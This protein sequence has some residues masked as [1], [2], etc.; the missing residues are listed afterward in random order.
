MVSC[1][2]HAIL[3]DDAKQLEKVVLFI[4]ANVINALPIPWPRCQELLADIP[5]KLP[6][7]CDVV[8]ALSHAWSHQTHPDPT[9]VKA[10]HVKTLLRSA[11][12][13]H[14]VTGEAFLF[15]D[16][17]S[18]NQNPYQE[19]Q[20]ERTPQEQQD[21]IMA[22]NAL[23]EIFFQ[24]DAVL[25]LDMTGP[26]LECEREELE[27]TFSDLEDFDLTSNF[28][29]YRRRNF[30][31]GTFCRIPQFRCT[32]ASSLQPSAWLAQLRR[33]NL[34]CLP[35]CLRSL[36][37][38]FTLKVN[39]APFGKRN[40]TSPSE[41]GWIAFERLISTIRVALTDEQ[42]SER[43]IYSNSPELKEMILSR[44]RLLRAAAASSISDL[45]Q[46]FD[47]LA[48]ELST[49][50]FQATTSDKKIASENSNC[51]D[52]ELVLEL[53]SRLQNRVMLPLLLTV[54][55]IN[56]HE[57]AQL[58]D[59]RADL[60]LQDGRGYTCLH[61]AARWQNVEVVKVLTARGANVLAQDKVG[62]CPAHLIPLYASEVTL[63]LLELLA[64]DK[65]SLLSMN[66]ACLKVV[67]RIE[68]WASTSLSGAPY[69]PAME[70]LCQKKDQF[71]ELQRSNNK[72]QVTVVPSRRTTDID[73]FTLNINIKGRLRPIQIVEPK[74]HPVAHVLYLGF[75]RFIPWSLQTPIL[76]KW[77][78]DMGIKIWAIN[79][80]SVD[81]SLMEHEKSPNL[82]IED[83]QL[84]VQTLLPGMG[85]QFYLVDSS[86]G[87][88]TAIAWLFRSKLQ[89]A[90]ILN[91][92]LFMAPNFET[93]ELAEQ[94]RTRMTYLGNIHRSRSLDEITAVFS[95]VT[96]PTGGF[97]A[98]KKSTSMYRSAILSASPS[99]WQL[100]SLQPLWNF[101]H[102][103]SIFSSSSEW[104]LDDAPPVIL[105][106]S[107][108]APQVVVAESM[109]RLLHRMAGSRMHFLQSSKW[110]W[111]LEGDAVVDQVT[112][113][114][115]ELLEAG[116]QHSTCTGD[117]G[118][119]TVTRCKLYA[120]RVS[121]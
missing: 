22:M 18:V 64:S 67:Q 89:G 70:W 68:T 15:C 90:L 87:P 105:A 47:L 112:E 32:Q 34:P 84:L 75:P 7:S 53:L 51:E 117:S 88:G 45:D 10:E 31:N 27:I 59:R 95:D 48:K 25:H 93:S 16:F 69:E 5:R 42:Y 44:S 76:E 73:C 107:D 2:P 63:Q 83:L 119:S 91:A 103:T 114:L 100:S 38:N 94:I 97:E 79:E 19:G 96:F 82:F 49:K 43:T 102:L 24:A 74:T 66:Q 110:S 115:D 106:C 81:A 36:S 80:D 54:R 8:F 39:P 29:A 17:L 41:R 1:S 104:H 55:N 92:H 23:P 12:P 121:L 52:L 98:V 85:G 111:Q 28:T 37:K 33:T 6:T 99:F 35:S 65:Q 116:Q 101:R 11:L 13:S 108:Q 3:Q 4:P 71:P 46:I 118:G 58:L 30:E 60:N 20:P 120:T 14:P 40:T 109:Q 113:L 50:R 56:L 61:N 21:F 57:C 62:N 86:F 9:G 72:Q 26:E 77:S 78:R